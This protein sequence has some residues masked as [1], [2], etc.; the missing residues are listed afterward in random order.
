MSTTASTSTAKSIKTNSAQMTNEAQL[1]RLCSREKWVNPYEVLL[2]GP[3]ATEEEIKSRF[4]RLSLL[5]HPDKC[6]GDEPRAIQAFHIIDIACK[7]LLDGDKRKVYQR[8]MR[9]AKERV[10]LERR[11]ENRRREIRGLSRLPEDTIDAEVQTM[12]NR[13]FREME[14]RKFHVDRS[15][16][17]ESRAK[18]ARD[19]DE[20]RREEEEQKKEQEK[21][22]ERSRDKR[23]N[24]WRTFQ[25]KKEKTSSKKKMKSFELRPPPCRMEERVSDRVDD[26]SQPM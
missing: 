15:D 5:V 1:E 11:N 9:E 7:T 8:V 20:K 4:K 22:W 19:E 23:V 26:R 16:W 18:R 21:E 24:C 10:D 2:L 3:E 6:P 14:E 17:M 13:I 12:C 25:V